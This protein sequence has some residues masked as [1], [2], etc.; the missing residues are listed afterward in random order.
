MAKRKERLKPLWRLRTLEHWRTPIRAHPLSPIPP[1]EA[2]G[3]APNY[4][5]QFRKEGAGALLSSIWQAQ[6][7]ARRNCIHC[8]CIAQFPFRASLLTSTVSYH[9]AYRQLRLCVFLQRLASTTVRTNR[10]AK[11][12]SAIK[13]RAQVTKLVADSQD[14][15]RHHAAFTLVCLALV[16][17]YLGSLHLLLLLILQC[18]TLRRRISL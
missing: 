4:G 10:D 3:N 2:L 14:I 12:V 5:V 7:A 11:A 6:V 18:C 16:S 13:C 15:S 17:L 8:H 1:A 9:V